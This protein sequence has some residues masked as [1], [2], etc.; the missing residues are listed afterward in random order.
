MKVHRKVGA[1]PHV[2]AL[3]LS[4][5]L[6]VQVQ[7]AGVACGLYVTHVA[8]VGGRG[9]GCAV[10]P[11][12]VKHLD[13]SPCVAVQFLVMASFGCQ[14]RIAV[15]GLVGVVVVLRHAVPTGI[16]TLSNTLEVA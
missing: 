15:D 14:A 11:A 13:D 8:N 6:K 16:K 7:F 3:A 10:L 2:E 4:R 5:C 9:P 12:F 1:V